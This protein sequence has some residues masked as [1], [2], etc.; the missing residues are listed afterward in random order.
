MRPSKKKDVAL[1]CY[2]MVGG[3]FALM[4]NPRFYSP[5]F[6]WNEFADLMGE[7]CETEIFIYIYPCTDEVKKY[8]KECGSEIAARLV[9]RMK[10]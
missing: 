9:S 5:N 3:R 1:A 10:E 4:Q 8:A 2:A 7:H 6:D